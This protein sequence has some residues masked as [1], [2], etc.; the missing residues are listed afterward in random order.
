M[1]KITLKDLSE[2][3]GVSQNTVS[4]VLR[5]RPGISE[6][7]REQ[8]LN[9]A[10]EM[11]YHERQKDCHM[12]NVCVLT[13]YKNNIDSY[14][15]GRLQNRIEYYLNK[16]KCT[17]ITVNNVETYSLEAIQD[18]CQ[19]N[20]IQGLIVVADVGRRMMEQ[21]EELNIPLLCAGFY[22]P[23][24]AADSVME[25][26]IIGMSLLMDQ[27]KER[28]IKDA[29]F[30]GSIHTDQGFFER[31]MT[32]SAMGN[33]LN[34]VIKTEHCILNMSYEQL[35][36]LREMAEVLG[37]I[38]SLPE[39]FICANDK[40][41]MTVIKAL[42]QNGKWIPQD[43]SVVGFD[44]CDLAML[45]TPT[46]ATVDNFLDK[47]ARSAVCRLLRILK[48]PQLPHER[49]LCSTEFVDGESLRKRQP[50]LP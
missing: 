7:T 41:A 37:N 4:L 33:K 46:I 28:G 5:G 34:I 11:G 49:I 17:T 1:K 20:D 48:E 8:I 43:I 16:N 40:I 30:I 44:N 15:F 32:A 38:E 29:G 6:A 21:L 39:A 22:V 12:P 50:H 3:I 31:W 24:M 42:Q 2:A 13:T 19:A 14:Y 27:L 9:K 35:G 45:S 47:Q 25:D 26:N 18:L 10:R 36:N 23:G